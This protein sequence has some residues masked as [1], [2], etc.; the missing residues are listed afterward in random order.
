[1]IP[2]HTAERMGRLSRG[3][4]AFTREGVNVMPW[5]GL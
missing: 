4:P 2:R 3:F 5:H 1:M